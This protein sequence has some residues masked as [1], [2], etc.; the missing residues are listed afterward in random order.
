LLEEDRWDKPGGSLVDVVSFAR[1]FHGVLRQY[2]FFPERQRVLHRV[3][4]SA[5]S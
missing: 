4:P 2:S 1:S 3:F 5:I